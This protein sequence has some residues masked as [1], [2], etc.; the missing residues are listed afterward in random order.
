MRTRTTTDTSSHYVIKF[1]KNFITDIRWK[2]IKGI[3]GYYL[4]SS[5]FDTNAIRFSSE[6]LALHW[7]NSNNCLN[8]NPKKIT[9]EK[10]TGSSRLRSLPREL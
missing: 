9:I 2:I 7:I 1:G 8:Y 10:V 4:Q 5:R 3:P 6:Y